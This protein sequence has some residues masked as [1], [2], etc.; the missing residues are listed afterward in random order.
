MTAASTAAAAAMTTAI[1]KLTALLQL[2]E[3][4]SEFIKNAATKQDLKLLRDELQCWHRVLCQCEATQ[5][6][7]RVETCSRRLRDLSLDLDASIDWYLRLTHRKRKPRGRLASFADEVVD[8]TAR[9]IRRRELAGEVRRFRSWLTEA[10]KEWH[11]TYRNGQPSSWPWAWAGTVP[12]EDRRPP[13]R[14]TAAPGSSSSSPASYAVSLAALDGRRDELAHDVVRG[15]N[16]GRVA[17]KSL[18]V[19]SIYGE[20]GLGK[21]ALAG[22]VYHAIR[23]QFDCVAWVSKPPHLTLKDILW[24]L[25]RQVDADAPRA[26]AADDDDV[27]DLSLRIKEYLQDKSIM[28]RDQMCFAKESTWQQSDGNVAYL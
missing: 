13:P 12:V 3:G 6:D 4:D 24:S 19:I 23:E 2:E 17:N 9:A 11:T 5:G 16:D 28:D 14:S 22:E 27:G 8:A 7:P 18:W 1:Q 10:C 26:A 20:D 15:N 25:L 21:T